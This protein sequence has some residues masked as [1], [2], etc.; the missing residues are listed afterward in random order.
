MHAGIEQ[1]SQG[2]PGVDLAGFH[3]FLN[4]IQIGQ[5]RIRA[6]VADLHQGWQRAAEALEASFIQ[7]DFR[8]SLENQDQV[9]D[10]VSTAQVRDVGLLRDL[11]VQPEWNIV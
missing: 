3:K 9:L 4:T 7:Y 10:A 11:S 2:G 1:Q 6:C 5:P 8:V